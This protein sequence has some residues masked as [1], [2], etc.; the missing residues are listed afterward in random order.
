MFFNIGWLQAQ[1]IVEKSIVDENGDAIPFVNILLCTGEGLISDANGNYILNTE[2]RADSVIVFSHVAYHPLQLK[3]KR[4]PDTLMMVS[5]KYELGEVEISK[6][7]MHKLLNRTF[8]RKKYVS[9]GN[10]FSTRLIGIGDSLVYFTE[11]ELKLNKI[12]VQART[13]KR[14]VCS[15]ISYNADSVGSYKIAF[16]IVSTFL[17][18]PY[19]YYKVEKNLAELINTSKLVRQYDDC[20][21][22]DAVKDSVSIRMYID[23]NKQCLIRFEKTIMRKNDSK[24]VAYCY[25]FRPM[26]HEIVIESFKYKMLIKANEQDSNTYNV[27]LCDILISDAKRGISQDFKMLSDLISFKQNAQVM[28]KETVHYFQN[29]EVE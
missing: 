5:R 18:N 15:N 6:L 22:I 23:K 10:Y 29:N 13:V 8:S 24:P 19:E 26:D 4:I 11:E 9:K 21:Q 20:Y 17:R 28:D 12:N 25:N 7:N 1:N 16:P 2:N 27:Y 3:A 14:K